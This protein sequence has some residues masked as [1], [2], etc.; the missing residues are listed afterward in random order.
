MD[1][2]INEFMCWTEFTLELLFTIAFI[3]WAIDI[4]KDIFRLFK[5]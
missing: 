1:K 2:L 4:V 3:H 5:K